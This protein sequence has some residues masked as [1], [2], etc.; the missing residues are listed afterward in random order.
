MLVFITQEEYDA[1]LVEAAEVEAKRRLG[2]P[3]TFVEPPV[4]YE[5]IWRWDVNY[6]KTIESGFVPVPSQHGDVYRGGNAHFIVYREA[7]VLLSPFASTS[8]ILALPCESFEAL[9]TQQAK[10][11]NT[12]ESRYIPATNLTSC[13]TAEIKALLDE[14]DKVD[15]HNI[16][17]SRATTD[18]GSA[19]QLRTLRK[20]K[21]CAVMRLRTKLTGNSFTSMKEPTPASLLPTVLASL[22]FDV[23]SAGQWD[24]R[25]KQVK[26]Q[27]DQLSG[28][29]NL[30]R[31]LSTW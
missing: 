7:E 1:H 20:R 3:T 26:M 13:H 18:A 10:K 6:P 12:R 16:A 28:V 22:T 17:I 11:K 31:R 2:I 29:A 25:M 9:A 27:V 14:A 19:V 30:Q 4:R 24:P 15:D 5:A 23:R 8:T 21:S